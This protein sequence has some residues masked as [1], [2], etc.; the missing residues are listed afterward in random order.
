MQNLNLQLIK[1]SSSLDKIVLIERVDTKLLNLLINSNGILQTT[2]R[3]SHGQVFENEKQQLEMILAKVKNNTLKVKHHISAH[4]YGRVYQEKSLSLF[5]LRRKLRHTLT[6]D[7]YTDIDVENAHP[8]L[9]KQIF[10]ANNIQPIYLQKYVNDRQTIFEEIINEYNIT[11]DDAKMLFISTMYGGTFENWLNGTNS[12][13]K[14][15][16]PTIFITNYINELAKLTK[17]II[18]ANPA[19]VKIISSKKGNISKSK[20]DASIVSIY[21]QEKERTVLEQ[22][23]IFMKD[24]NLIVNNEAMLCFDGIMI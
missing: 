21:L 15:K 12:D 7:K 20:M 10:E 17:F 16:G 9:L 6:R 19:L 1:T 5:C 22:V 2:K 14:D 18:D 13:K 11:R 3:E 24:K 4:G 23:F 8:Q